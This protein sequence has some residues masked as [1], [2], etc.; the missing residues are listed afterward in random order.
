MT[1]AAG[2]EA[3]GAA[4]GSGA[5]LG[6]DSA[7]GA[8]AAGPEAGQPAAS[9]AGEAAGANGGAAASGAELML[10]SVSDDHS[11]RLFQARAAGLAL[12]GGGALHAAVSGPPAEARE[13]P[14]AEAQ[15]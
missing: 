11:V 5:G 3:G 15:R 2:R 14:G 7:A 10:A 4:E 9:G 8:G 12:E 1:E 6:A 13:G